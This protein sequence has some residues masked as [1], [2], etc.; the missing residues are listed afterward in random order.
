MT[1]I[2]SVSLHRYEELVR[3][4]VILFGVLLRA[5]FHTYLY[6]ST[7]LYMLARVQYAE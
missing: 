3:W 7:F 4:Y 2:G 5:Y 6:I 1:R